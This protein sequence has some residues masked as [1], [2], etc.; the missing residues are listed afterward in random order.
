MFVNQVAHL[1]LHIMI[2]VPWSTVTGQI[3]VNDLE[4]Q[5]NSLYLM[6]IYNNYIKY[7][8][9]LIYIYMYIYRYKIYHYSI[10]I[11]NQLLYQYITWKLYSTYSCHMWKVQ[12]TRSHSP[13]PHSLWG[14][15]SARNWSC[16]SS[17]ATPPKSCG[18]SKTRKQG[19]FQWCTFF[20]HFLN[21]KLE[22]L[23]LN[24]HGYFRLG[25]GQQSNDAISAKFSFQ[26]FA[27]VSWG[28]IGPAPL[29]RI[30]LGHIL[31]RYNCDAGRHQ[32]QTS[33]LGVAQPFPKKMRWQ[34]SWSHLLLHELFTAQ[35]WPNLSVGTATQRLGPLQSSPR[36][37]SGDAVAALQPSKT[38][39]GTQWN[40]TRTQHRCIQCRWDFNP[41]V[42]RR[43]NDPACNGGPGL[44]Q[45]SSNNIKHL[46]QFQTCLTLRS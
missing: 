2:I 43:F 7:S 28:L 35:M 15:R 20:H 32:N 10:Y 4:W 23:N 26:L 27:E 33:L 30:L 24:F 5:R 42:L 38:M 36:L 44:H 8:Y 1:A 11:Y 18:D 37:A 21:I 6:M 46:W 40:R 31:P 19:T 22:H 12:R 41:C 34:I 17:N 9:D 45:T 14:V 39:T 16:A 29:W 13:C 25:H 3:E